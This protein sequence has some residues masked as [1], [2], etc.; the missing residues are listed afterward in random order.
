[1]RDIT[2]NNFNLNDI[3]K[4]PDLKLTSNKKDIIW[5]E[6][7]VEKQITHTNV[8]GKHYLLKTNSRDYSEVEIC[9]SSQVLSYFNSDS[10]TEKLNVYYDSNIWLPEI[11]NIDYKTRYLVSSG[12]YDP[13]KNIYINVY[14][15]LLIHNVMYNRIS[16]DF[17]WYDGGLPIKGTYWTNIPKFITD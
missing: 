5:S 6:N 10:V 14:Y 4:L 3:V 11:Y 13:E 9:A 1:M 17:A 7:L 8:S 12:A 15:L 16:L 2:K